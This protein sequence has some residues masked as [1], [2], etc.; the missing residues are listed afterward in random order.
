MMFYNLE[1]RLLSIPALVA[2]GRNVIFGNYWCDIRNSEQLIV[3]VN[4]IG[5]MY[6]LKAILQGNKVHQV[7]EAT[8]T[9]EKSQDIDVWHARLGHFPEKKYP[10]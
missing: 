1:R 7:I 5:K 10:F 9:G 6:I 4:M 2:K 3:R 8:A